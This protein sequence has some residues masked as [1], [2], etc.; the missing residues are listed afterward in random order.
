MMNNHNNDDTQQPA[1][2]LT[3]EAEEGVSYVEPNVEIKLSA[4]KRMEC[5]NIVKEIKNFG[6]NQRQTLYLIHLLALELENREVMTAL[7]K[8]IGE[9]RDKIKISQL[10]LPGDSQT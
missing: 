5:R 3:D 2:F 6:I 8:A 9:N 1:P 10:I 7:T 4:A